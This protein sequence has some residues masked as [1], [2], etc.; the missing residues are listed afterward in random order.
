MPIYRSFWCAY[1]MAMV[2]EFSSSVVVG[3]EI[4]HGYLCSKFF[5]QRLSYFILRGDIFAQLIPNNN[6]KI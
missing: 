6:I 1:S 5:N 3:A 2:L 4:I